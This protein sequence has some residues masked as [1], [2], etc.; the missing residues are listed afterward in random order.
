MLEKII[1][2]KIKNQTSTV[3]KTVLKL[4]VNTAEIAMKTQNELG[5]EYEILTGKI[6]NPK[7]KIIRVKEDQLVKKKEIIA[8]MA[9]PNLPDD[10]K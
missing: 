9:N 4:N 7:I 6:L 10:E 5:H 1:N 2:P 3:T 8:K